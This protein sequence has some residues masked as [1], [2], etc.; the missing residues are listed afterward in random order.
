MSNVMGTKTK[1]TKIDE[2]HP[3][4]EIRDMAYGKAATQARRD[5]LNAQLATVLATPNRDGKIVGTGSYQYV[6]V[7]EVVEVEGRVRMRGVCQCCGGEQVVENGEIVLHGYRRPG[8]G[9]TV[10]RCI[11]VR[12]KP[13]QVENTLTIE[14]RDGC[15]ATLA[16]A[17][18][19]RA[20]FEKSLK[21]AKDA[22]YLNDDFDRIEP[23]AIS[24][25]PRAPH[26]RKPSDE[27]IAKY[28]AALRDWSTRN[29]RTAKYDRLDVAV[30][31]IEQEIWQMEGEL[32]HFEKLLSSGVHGSPLKQE[33]V[34]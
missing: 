17:Q 13:L 22:L 18:K 28:E 21:A 2:L 27:E 31:T 4:R 19:K 20:T 3:P 10:G 16:D 8:Y 15:A 23:D 29:P 12:R 7:Y 11:G 32:R 14:L 9:Y 26:G 6:A 34:A 25:K 24:T 30:R 33:V 1:R 5:W